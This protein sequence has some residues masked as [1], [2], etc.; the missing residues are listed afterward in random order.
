MR[1]I[2]IANQKG[3]VGK[4]TTSI[5][6]AAGLAKKDKKVLLVD[7]DPQGNSTLGYG[8]D[9][10][11]I[12]TVGDLLIN[13]KC[14]IKDV[15]QKTYIPK[16]DILPSDISLA[17]CE[18][19]MPTLGKEFRLRKKL[20]D[21]KGYDYVIIDCPPTFGALAINAFLFAK[22]IILPIDLSYFTLAGVDN[23]I[24]SINHINEN[25]SHVAGHKINIMG[26]LVNFF[27]TRTKH[28]REVYKQ[29][30]DI[31]GSKVFKTSIPQNVKFKESQ[32]AAKAIYDY[33]SKCSG[34][35]AFEK[36]TQ[37]ILKRK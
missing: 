18:L 24:D 36:L 1:T 34:S 32:S 17:G 21:L 29:V 5:N 33:D 11:D 12:L 23:F 15:V 13:D 37:E 3:G 16:L 35:Q 30:I 28:S 27:D 6:V 8:I 4:S 2:A 26:I 22:E 7:M 20:D 10:Q 31:F 25:V 14:N 9:T 19:K